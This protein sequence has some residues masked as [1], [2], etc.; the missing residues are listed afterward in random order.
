MAYVN[1]TREQNKAWWRKQTT[2]VKIEDCE[3]A[4]ISQNYSGKDTE[5]DKN[6][7]LLMTN[8]LKANPAKNLPP[9][10]AHHGRI[11]P[12]VIDNGY[13]RYKAYLKAK[14][15]MIPIVLWNDH[16]ALMPDYPW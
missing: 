12:Y 3:L 14:R 6:T 2:W 16:D 11:H 15:I 4:F 7:I 8:W 1:W 13:H 10:L 9:L 5:W